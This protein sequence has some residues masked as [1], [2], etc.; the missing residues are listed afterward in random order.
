MGLQACS[1]S[2]QVVGMAVLVLPQNK[3]DPN[4]VHDWDSSV[5]STRPSFKGKVLFW[6]FFRKR[7][8]S[9]SLKI[10]VFF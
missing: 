10:S 3:K 7:K 8:S 5:G 9:F 6:V 1:D 4:K 2:A